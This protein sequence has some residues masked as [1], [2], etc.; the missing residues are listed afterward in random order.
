MPITRI[1]NEDILDG[2]ITDVDVSGSNIDGL[3]NV[4][5]LRTLGTG[6][7]QAAA[8]DDPRFN[9]TGSLPTPDCV[10]QILFAINTS[11]FAKSLP[12]TTHNGWLVNSNGYLIVS[13][14]V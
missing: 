6:S 3:A 14:A 1:D 10:G 5:S 9:N 7:Q 4:P 2:T 8:G 11:K 13:G 12:I